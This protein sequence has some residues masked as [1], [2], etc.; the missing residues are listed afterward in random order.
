MSIPLFFAISGEDIPNIPT[1]PPPIAWMACH[2]SPYGAGLTD[3]PTRLPAGSILILD[4]RIPM[5]HHDPDLILQQLKA[6]VEELKCGRVL[7][8]FLRE[9]QNVPVERMIEEIPCPV[10]VTPKYG[11]ELDCALFLPPV[12]PHIPLAEYLAPWKDRRIWLEVAPD[13]SDITVTP[14]G[15]TTI[16]VPFPQN[17]TPS[18]KEETLCCHYTFS[19]QPKEARFSLF[20][21][22]DD[23][24]SLLQQA[25]QT[26]I[27][28]A[29]GLFQ[30]LS[31][32]QHW[33]DK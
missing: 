21:T 29:I 33:N 6:A 17:V 28:L 26:N 25:E 20:R 2:F 22:L 30:E 5:T 27:E 11:K 18:H 1:P 4:D 9:D 13:G 19:V 10:G 16:P 32:L 24:G 14:Q 12:P 7:L 31:P 8:E 23:I 3:L 15:T